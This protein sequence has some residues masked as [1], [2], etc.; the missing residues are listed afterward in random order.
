MR[1]AEWAALLWRERTTAVAVA[2]GVGVAGLGLALAQP[3][4]Y[5]AEAKVLVRLGQE[6]VFQP[7]VGGAG[8]GAAPE[9]VALVNAELALLRSEGVIGRVVDEVG[10]EALYPSIAGAQDPERARQLAEEAFA[11]ALAVQAAP[12]SPVIT[13]GFRHRDREVAAKALNTLMTRY[14]SFR[15]EVLNAPAEQVLTQEGGAVQGRLAAAGAALAQFLNTHGIGSFEADMAAAAALKASTEQDLGQ[16]RAQRREV[17]GRLAALRARLRTEP[18]DIALYVDSDARGQL[19]QLQME[20]EELLAQYRPDS[21][22]VRTIEA[23]ISQ[24]EAF[25]ATPPETATRRGPNPVR[26]TLATELYSAEA[27]ARALAGRE[28]ALT[29]QITDVQARLATLQRLEPE[30]RRLL[31]ERATL[32]ASAGDLNRRAEETRAARVVADAAGQTV[33]I[34]QPATAPLRATSLRLPIAAAGALLGLIFGVVAAL[35]VGLRRDRF[36]SPSAAARVLR[37]PVL[38]VSET[39]PKPAK[40]GKAA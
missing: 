9:L 36:A 5:T 12:Q 39:A 23:R 35:L 22:P 38:A 2:A 20:R 7:T 29:G 8:A 16:A 31:A 13:L 27:E 11:K 21:V 14:L 34:M 33:S 10:V 30:Y 37:A 15:Q 6:Y 4:H 24:L 19:V 1:L 32:E 17:E 3:Q 26:Q 40:R 18:S 25:L 28:Q